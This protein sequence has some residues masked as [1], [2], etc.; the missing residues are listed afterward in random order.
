MIKY[1]R[2]T[3]EAHKLNVQKLKSLPADEAAAGRHGR[4]EGLRYTVLLCLLNRLELADG[5]R[6]D[7][8]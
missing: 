3:E 4:R 8:M 2:T 5:F 7:L 1:S 6:V